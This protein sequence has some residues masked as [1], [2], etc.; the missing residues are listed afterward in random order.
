MEPLGRDLCGR[1][2]QLIRVWLLWRDRVD[3]LAPGGRPFPAERFVWFGVDSPT[4]ITVSGA[5]ATL[6]VAL[7]PLVAI[8]VNQGARAPRAGSDRRDTT[9]QTFADGTPPVISG[10]LQELLALGDRG[11]G[12]HR[13]VAVETVELQRSLAGRGEA[14]VAA[15][16][17]V[18]DGRRDRAGDLERCALEHGPHLVRVHAGLA[19]RELPVLAHDQRRHA[20]RVRGGH[21]G[22]LQE[23]VIAAGAVRAA[24]LLH[25]QGRPG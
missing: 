25:P 15:L 6:S 22:A 19:V 13:A 9:R 11:P 20:D 12:V 10:L 4:K 14:G 24:V 2:A 5:R 21:R 23:L 17:E 16:V 3:S 7:A 18:I 8:M 1:P